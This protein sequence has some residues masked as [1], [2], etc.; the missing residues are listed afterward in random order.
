MQQV[1]DITENTTDTTTT[2]DKTVEKEDSLFVKHVKML[3][4]NIQAGQEIKGKLTLKDSRDVV[5]AKK[6]LLDFDGSPEKKT[7]DEE[8][9]ALATFVRL[10]DLLQS[11]GVFH[12]DGAVTLLNAL[13]AL[14]TVLNERKDNSAKFAELQKRLTHKK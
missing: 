1:E 4:A 8:I 3:V 13:E 6:I 2:Q 9:N 7:S 10:C 5:N 11:T 14:E 12:L